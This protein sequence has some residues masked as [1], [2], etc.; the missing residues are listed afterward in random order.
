MNEAHLDTNGCC[1]WGQGAHEKLR[2]F[3]IEICDKN[4]V[5]LRDFNYRG[6]DWALNCVKLSKNT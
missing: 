6:I 5:L 1:V 3:I 2:K 4:F